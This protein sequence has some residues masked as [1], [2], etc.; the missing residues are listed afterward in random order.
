M[1]D[2]QEYKVGWAGYDARPPN[3]FFDDGTRFV[4]YPPRARREMPGGEWT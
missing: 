1:D 3:S 2:E 4:I